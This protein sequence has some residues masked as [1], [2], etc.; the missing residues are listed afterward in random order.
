MSDIIWLPCWDWLPLAAMLRLEQRQEGFWNHLRRNDAWTGAVAGSGEEQWESSNVTAS[1]RGLQMEWTWKVWERSQVGFRGLDLS[2]WKMEPPRTECERTSCRRSRF[3]G[4]K[5]RPSAQS[6]WFRLRHGQ[7]WSGGCALTL[8]EPQFLLCFLPR[9][10]SSST[11]TSLAPAGE[12]GLLKVLK[13]RLCS[14]LYVLL[15]KA[16]KWAKWT[17]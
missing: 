16:R 17:F 10:I 8:P 14:V 3:S 12:A 13:S 1:P 15:H 9:E 5:I 11:F 6:S 4:Q 2:K 7:T